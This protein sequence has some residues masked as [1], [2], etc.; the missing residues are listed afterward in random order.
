MTLDDVKDKASQN[1][2]DEL[3]ESKDQTLDRFIYALGIP[4]VGKHMSR[5]LCRHFPDLDH[6]QEVDEDKLREIYEIGPEV[7]RS[8]VA[9]FS[10][11]NNRDD[12]QRILDAGVKLKNP[13]S[14]QKKQPLEG[15]TFVFTGELESWTRDEA[16]KLVE[17]NGG[18]ASSSVSSKT[19]YVIAGPG[20]GSKLEQAKKQDIEILDEDEF[21]R[22][23][24]SEGIEIPE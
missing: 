3:E 2:L 12:I 9:F 15:L 18:H 24:K 17:E 7:A 8:V 1:I 6:L 23:L 4:L 22:I 11:K 16:H 14:K 21:K 19:D 20:A 13:L 5:V 10:D